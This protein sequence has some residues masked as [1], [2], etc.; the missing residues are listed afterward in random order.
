MGGHKITVK[1]EPYHVWQLPG[2]GAEGEELRR[3]ARSSNQNYFSIVCLS[4][5]VMSDSLDTMDCGLPSSSVHGIFQAI[6]LECIAR[7]SS[8]PRDRTQVSCTAGRL[9]L[10][11]Q[12]IWEKET[13]ENQGIWF[14]TTQTEDGETS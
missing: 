5:S 6:I 4:C 12:N 8:W 10:S 14:Q 13:V 9:C 11:H 1:G 7:G 2:T 3:N